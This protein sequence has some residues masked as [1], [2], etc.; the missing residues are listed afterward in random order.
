MI[1]QGWEL[2]GSRKP[3]KYPLSIRKKNKIYKRY[4]MKKIKYKKMREAR[5]EITVSKN[6][7]IWQII[8]VLLMMASTGFAE[9]TAEDIV[10]WYPFNGNAVDESGNGN[11][12]IVIGATLA[13]DR[14]GNPD[15]AYEFDGIDDRIVCGNDPSTIP[16][17]VTVS[18]WVKPSNQFQP[19]DYLER[20]D[21]SKRQQ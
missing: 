12:G 13:E 3:Y 21:L 9:I 10:A 15:S 7:Q 1:L 8:I 20:L 6:I 2:K 4:K 14:F 16:E 17:K 11:D 18:V 19:A 5:I